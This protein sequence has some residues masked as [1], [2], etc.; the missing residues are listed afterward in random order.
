MDTTNFPNIDSE[1]HG[2]NYAENYAENYFE[3]PP[4]KL[5]DRINDE[6]ERVP[7]PLRNL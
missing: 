6:S 1:N 2:E 4:Q 7:G 5:I 3:N